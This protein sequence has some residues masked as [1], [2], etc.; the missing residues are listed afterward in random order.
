LRSIP[1]ER[2]ILPVFEGFMQAVND[3][4]LGAVG[5]DPML[6]VYIEQNYLPSL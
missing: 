6:R 1:L 4:L 5:P 2:D 3:R